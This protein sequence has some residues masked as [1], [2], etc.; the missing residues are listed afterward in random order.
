[1]N[2][3]SLFLSLYL[4]KL[5]SRYSAVGITNDYGLDDRMI[6]VRILVEV[7]IFSSPFVQTGSGAHPASCPMGKVALPWGVKWPECEAEHS[8]P[9]SA[10]VKKTWIHPLPN[11]PYGIVLS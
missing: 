3:Y 5:W 4:T 6:G 11:S 10:K 8:P 2:F 7:R 9:T 1:M